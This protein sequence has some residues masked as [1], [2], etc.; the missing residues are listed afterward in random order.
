MVFFLCIFIKKESGGPIQQVI[1]AGVIPILI[2]NMT[3]FEFPTLQKDCA[4]ALTNIAAGSTEQTEFL[5]K[6][7]VL[8]PLIAA[9]DSD[10][11]ELQE[12]C[13]W[14]I[15]NIA[16]DSH[17]FRDKILE[18][19][20]GSLINIGIETKNAETFKN[21]VWTLS[22]LNRGKPVPDYKKVKDSATVFAIALEKYNNEVEILN[23]ALWA[24]SCLSGKF[25][26]F[27]TIY[28]FKKMEMMSK[29]KISLI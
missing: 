17:H 4:W 7:G 9:L 22:N 21:V 25:S 11:L 13:V 27:L 6:Q 16:G 23:D 8:K 24:L 15:G 18:I 5:L 14:A 19:G 28:S 26:I 3:K 2:S 1:D 29:Y 12:Q 10:N 20:I